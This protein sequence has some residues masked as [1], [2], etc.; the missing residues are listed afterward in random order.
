MD[1]ADTFERTPLVLGALP[2]R[3]RINMP[4]A[5]VF[6]VFTELLGPDLEFRWSAAAICG[7]G[8]VARHL[9]ENG[10]GAC[11]DQTG[12]LASDMI[13]LAERKSLRSVAG[14]AAEAAAVEKMGW[15]N[16]LAEEGGSSVPPRAETTTPLPPPPTPPALKPSLPASPP[17]SPP[18]CSLSPVLKRSK[19]TDSAILRVLLFS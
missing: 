18:V 15:D 14:C 17:A 9:I 12:A 2:P 4:A 16:H 5:C 10:A 13:E 3:P 19:M 11:R 8:E 6:R 7:H 1:A